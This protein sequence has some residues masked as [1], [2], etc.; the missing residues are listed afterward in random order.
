MTFSGYRIRISLTLAASSACIYFSFWSFYFYF[1]IAAENSKTYTDTKLQTKRV[2]RIFWLCPQALLF[3]QI[4]CLCSVYTGKSFRRRCMFAFFWHFFYIISFHIIFSPIPFHFVL[5]CSVLLLLEL[6]I[7]GVLI[8][9]PVAGPS[10]FAFRFS[11][12]SLVL[13]CSLRL[14]LWLVPLLCPNPL[15]WVQPKMRHLKR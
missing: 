5:F 9:Y 12:W 15:V 1:K 3:L 4:L 7:C 13:V 6:P 11:P 14:W 2:Q 8:C 10:F